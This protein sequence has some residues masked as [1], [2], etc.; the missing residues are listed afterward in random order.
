M[1]GEVCT[2]ND[3]CCGFNCAVAAVGAAVLVAGTVAARHGAEL[4]DAQA[5]RAA[6]RAAVGSGVAA[7][8]YRLA[9]A[10]TLAAYRA[11]GLV[12]RPWLAPLPRRRLLYFSSGRSA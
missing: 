9:H 4:I 8:A 2:D 6:E 5:A 7:A 3:D 11:P 10:E 12:A 1:V